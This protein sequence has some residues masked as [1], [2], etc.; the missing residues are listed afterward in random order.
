M[1]RLGEMSNCC[2]LPLGGGCILSAVIIFFRF[3]GFF[4]EK[5]STIKIINIILYAVLCS[6][7]MLGI[8]FK[9]FIIFY[10]VT[11]LIIM[12]I[13]DIIII[14]FVILV[15]YLSIGNNLN[16]TPIAIVLFTL[17]TSMLIMLL[18]LN[19]FLSMA[20]VL[21]E[22]GTGWENKNYKQIRAEK[23]AII[24][25]DEQKILDNQTAQNNYMI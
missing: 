16:F 19:I 17:F 5:N 22:G 23:D 10:I 12:Y 20:N 18:F 8:I 4:M 13:I 14:F 7:I 25:K 24:S 6:F 15:S 1:G 9:N 11:A 3:L 21:K 2:C